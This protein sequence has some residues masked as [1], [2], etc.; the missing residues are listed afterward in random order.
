MSEIRD[1]LVGV[2]DGW[3][4]QVQGAELGE[5]G[6]G[7]VAEGARTARRRRSAVRTAATAAGVALVVAGAWWAVEAREPTPIAPLPTASGTATPTPVPSD[8]AP[9]DLSAVLP[10]ATPVTEEV[11]AQVTE[12]WVLASWS[13][14]EPGSQEWTPNSVYLFAPDGTAYLVLDTP[15]EGTV[16]HWVPGERNA[17]FRLCCD[18]G[19]AYFSLDTGEPAEPPEWLATT[20]LFIKGFLPDGRAHG[21]VGT[22]PRYVVQGPDSTVE[23]GPAG[24]LTF[25]EPRFSPDGALAEEGGAVWSTT[26]GE[27]VAYPGELQDICHNM[28]WYDATRLA[29]AC[30]DRDDALGWVYSDGSAWLLDVQTK[31]ETQA[32]W[33]AQP[34]AD[35]YSWWPSS[36]YVSMPGGGVLAAAGGDPW[37]GMDQKNGHEVPSGPPGRETP[38]AG[39]AT[40]EWAVV[41]LGDA[42][43]HQCAALDV[44]RVDLGL[45]S[46]GVGG[47]IYEADGADEAD[48]CA[49]DPTY[50]ALYRW[51]DGA[52]TELVPVLHGPD[53]LVGGVLSWAG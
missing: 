15:S 17:W 32:A 41:D 27:P 49:P 29:F 4:A 3:A 6:E 5:A 52:L 7:R 48:G 22:V 20:P 39:S 47:A 37:L 28:G 23:I 51:D 42:N 36:Q 13:G 35:G 19:Y 14:G 10:E 46:V 26:T 1:H 16:M 12:G 44:V 24:D 18:A 2:R 25:W 38:Y 31:T 53:E 50:K 43:A 33:P 11:W 40:D 21:L 9:I 34:G 45:V 30:G 8:E